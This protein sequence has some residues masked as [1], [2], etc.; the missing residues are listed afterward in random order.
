MQCETDSHRN[1]FF[2]DGHHRDGH[3]AAL[4]RRHRG[5]VI[6][7]QSYLSCKQKQEKN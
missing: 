4:P 5:V 7:G 6:V 1:G 3:G 2:P